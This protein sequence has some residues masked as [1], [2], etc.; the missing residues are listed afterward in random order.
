MPCAKNDPHSF[1]LGAAI[2]FRAVKLVAWSTEGAQI[3]KPRASE[4]PPWVASFRP[5]GPVL[6]ARADGP[7]N[8]VVGQIPSDPPA[9]AGGLWGIDAAQKRIDRV[10]V[11]TSSYQRTHVI[12]ISPRI[13]IK[14]VGKPHDIGRVIAVD[15]ECYKRGPRESFGAV[16]TP[17]LS[18]CIFGQVARANRE[19]TSPRTT[20]PSKSLSKTSAS[21][22]G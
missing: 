13:P 14:V 2:N 11:E 12:Q 9:C 7:G 10:V 20:K 18:N 21:S 17:S 8:E 19:K 5:E 4:P 3:T 1:Q 15:S 22:G 6:S 16:G